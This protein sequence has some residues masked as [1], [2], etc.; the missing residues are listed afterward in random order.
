MSTSVFIFKIITKFYSFTHRCSI[1][2]RFPHCHARLLYYYKNIEITSI[3][4]KNIFYVIFLYFCNAAIAQTAQH[5]ALNR[6]AWV[7]SS[8]GEK[9]PSTLM[10]PGPCK[11]RRGCNVLQV[12]TQIVPLGVPKRGSLPLRGGSQL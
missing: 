9:P 5:S 12:P 10:A 3:L 7:R 8:L 4:S 11:I 2:A 6:R 1:S